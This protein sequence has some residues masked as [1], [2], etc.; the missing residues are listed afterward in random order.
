[1][2]TNKAHM[3]MQDS[4]L[5]QPYSPRSTV[6]CVE[7][8][9]V[10]TKPLKTSQEK[11]KEAESQSGS[12]EDLWGFRRPQQLRI[13]TNSGPVANSGGREEKETWQYIISWFFRLSYDV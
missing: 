7:G 1:M 10:S 13:V 8:G 11:L 9:Y 12:S 5:I 2:M 4:R 6:G 3:L